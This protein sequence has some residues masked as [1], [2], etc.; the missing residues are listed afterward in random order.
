[1]SAEMA[2]LGL[3]GPTA[4]YEAS[5]GGL[6]KAFVDSPR[7]DLLIANLGEHWHAPETNFKPYGCCGSVHPHVD[8][9]LSLR[10][11]LAPGGRVRIGMA[12]VVDVQCGYEYKPS[13]ALNAQMSG[14][15]S[16]AVALLD[17]AVLPAQFEPGRL[18]SADVIAMA[19]RIEIVQDPAL[20][21]RYPAQFCGW[22]EVET[23]SGEVERID[24]DNPS[25]SA[26]NPDR[27]EAILAKFAALTAPVLS[28]SGIERLQACFVNFPDSS[29]DEILTIAAS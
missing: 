8:A 15:Y 23:R 7:P 6:L 17:G 5:D 24:V 10:H 11:R 4:I 1:M 21:A 27:G 2:K 12:R 25:G 16:V 9:A 3:T 13:S 29:V 20:D 28:A 26:Q 14:R 19:K 18:E 22:V